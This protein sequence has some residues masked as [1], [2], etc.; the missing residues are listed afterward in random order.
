MIASDAPSDIR[1][2][3]GAIALLGGVGAF[4][5]LQLV[6]LQKIGFAFEYPLDDVYIHLAMA[7]EIARGGY[8]VNSGEYASA[9][10]SILYPFLLAPFPDSES[11]RFLPL[12]WNVVGLVLSCLLWGRI[13]LISGLSGAVAWSLAFVGPIVFGAFS[14]AFV[15]MEHTLHAAASLAIVYGLGLL[16]LRD[17]VSWVLLAGVFF[18][19]VL[20]FEGLALSLLAAGVLFLLGRR[21]VS[22]FALALALIP[23]AAYS[24][25]LVSLG[26]D[27]LP[28]SIQAKLTSNANADLSFLERRIGTFGVNVG[29]L[30]GLAILLMVLG[31]LLMRATVPALKDNRLGLLVLVVVAAGLGHLFLGQIGWLERYEHY[32]LF[33]LAGALVLLAGQA[34]SMSPVVILALAAP[35]VVAGWSYL[36]NSWSAYQWSPQGI[37]NQQ[38][39]MARFAQDYAEENVA[40]NDLGRVV[41]GNPNYVLDLWGLANAEARRI[42]I[43]APVPAWAGP[44]ARDRDVVLIMIYEEWL[45]EAIDPSWIRLGKLQLR[46]PRGFLGGREVVFFARSAEDVP[47]LVEKLKAFQPTMNPDTRFH[48]EETF[49]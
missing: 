49:R 42:R 15:G 12:F 9:A 23:I 13:I 16:I 3:Y 27:P 7:S 8:G 29:K 46:L 47:E 19:P 1:P 30:G 40:V 31:A 34:G 44:L 37:H 4:L 5:L 48:F 10:S 39:Q 28:S 38:G 35:M 11:Q 2:A 32:A 17:R 43:F 14:T 26:L 36:Q 24:A 20:R 18:A 41:W 22:F 45:E 33:A 25:W 6:A 21:G